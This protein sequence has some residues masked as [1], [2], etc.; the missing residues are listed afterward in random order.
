[1]RR[2][3]LLA[4]ALTLSTFPA[5]A[6]PACNAAGDPSWLL[7]AAVAPNPDGEPL[8]MLPLSAVDRER[9]P[10]R[11]I[12]T[13]SCAPY[14]SVSC[15]YTPPSS[16]VAVDRNCSA[17]LQGHV[18]CGSG[19]YIFCTPS[20]PEC[21]EGSFKWEATGSCCDSLTEQE[22]FQCVGGQ[23]TPLSTYRC[24]PPACGGV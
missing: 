19:P 3:S 21:T 12:C 10:V 20:C 4:L 17:G 23:W 22:K 7:P 14:A 1:M 13:A 16:C 9:I 24:R 15:S 18:K 2:L 8:A 11:A 6:E 5:V